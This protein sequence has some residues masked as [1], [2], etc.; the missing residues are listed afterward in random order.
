[1]HRRIGRGVGALGA[2]LFSALV[3]LPSAARAAPAPATPGLTTT[4][5]TIGQIDDI[6]QPVPGLFKAAEDGTAAYVDYINSTGGLNGRKLVL[7]AR[8]SNFDSATVVNETRQLAQSDF[9]MVGGFSLLDQAEKPVIDATGIPDVA[10]PISVSLA[11]DPHVYSVAPSALNTTPTG[12]YDWAKRAFPAQSQHVGILYSSATPSS[13]ADELGFDKVLEGQGLR[14]L[15][16]RGFGP[17]EFTFPADIVK[18]KAAGVQMFFNE[19]LPGSYAATEAREAAQQGLHVVNI[20]GP[21]AYVNNM[22]Q[23]AGS[24]ADG[25]Y[26]QMAN[27]LFQGE[28]ARAIPEVALFDH[29]VKKVDPKVFQSTTPLAALYGW[30]SAMLFAQAFKAAGPN[31]TRASFTA[32]LDKVTN[33]DAAGLLPPGENPAQNISSRCFL[34]ARY[35]DGRWQRVAPTP[36]TGFICAGHLIYRPGWHPERR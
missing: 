34:V 26:L 4:S 5:V 30:A 20:E 17:T 24:A 8:D 32:Q 12:P 1:M 28:D 22:G 35:D 10:V 15:Y 7:D 19:E 14:V 11:N 6:S 29:W 2:A 16:R 18:M 36:K 9:A 3:V 23:L 33:F 21:A 27:A 31:P 25:M 13:T